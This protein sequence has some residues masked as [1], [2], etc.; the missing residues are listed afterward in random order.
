[1]SAMNAAKFAIKLLEK[2][3]KSA[4]TDKR[5]GDSNVL[6]IQRQET[7]HKELNVKTNKGR[8]ITEE[9]IERGGQEQGEHN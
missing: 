2:R 5:D 3:S 1:M 7:V 4:K 8:Q 6:L 9:A